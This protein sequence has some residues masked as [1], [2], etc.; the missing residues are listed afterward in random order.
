MTEEESLPGGRSTGAVKIGNRVH[1]P[2]GPWTPSVHA[3]LRHLEEAGFE[4]APRACGFDEQGREVLTYLEGDVVGDRF[5]WPAW[6]TAD[7]T[8]EQVGRWLRRV[9]DLT[10][11]FEP[12][13]GAVWFTGATMQPGFVIGH[14]DAAPYNAVMNGD[15]LLG[16][17]DWD[18]ASPSSR[19]HDIAFSVMLW[20]PLAKVGPPSPPAPAEQRRRVRL[21]LDAYGYDGDRTVFATVI[22]ERARRQ[23]G[24]IR[25]MDAQGHPASAALLPMAVAM[26]Q[27]AIDVEALPG[28]FWAG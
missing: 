23:A 14:Q 15:R 2:A 20:A 6:A 26:E 21:L 12:P 7:S 13:A 18:I 11:G 24:V 4:G 8:L 16:F 1:K 10:A 9:H 19:E 3:V 17:V 27:A 25:A 28:D 5:P 22:P